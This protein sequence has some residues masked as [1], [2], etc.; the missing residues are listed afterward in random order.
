MIRSPRSTFQIVAAAPHWAGVLAVTFLVTASST[1]L[2]LET[3]VGRLALLDQLE[4][5]TLAIGRHVDDAQYATLEEISEHGGAYALVTS[6]A[7]GPL[8]AVALSAVLFAA[9]RIATGGGATPRQVL[10]VVSHAGVIMALRHVIAA[11]V[12]YARETLAS[13]LALSA[14]VTI[15]EA[16]PLARVAAAVDLFLIWWVITLAVGM[17]VLYRRPA[18]RLVLVFVGLYILLTSVLA[19]GMAVTGGTA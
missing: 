6:L 19:I 16:S 5:T 1:T 14:F 4:W 18:R 13:P 2:L 7:S 15:D 11:P 12:A 3:E 8:L 17:S 10:A 9:F